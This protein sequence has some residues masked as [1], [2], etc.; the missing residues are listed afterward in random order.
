[1]PSL[2]VRTLIGAVGRRAKKLLPHSIVRWIQQIRGQPYQIPKGSVRFG[3]LRR[4]SPISDD[5][6]SDRGT[7]VDRYY[8]ETF[9]AQSAKDVRGRVLEADSNL[10]TRR[11]GGGRV[12]RSDVLSV[13]ANSHATIVGDLVEVGTL[14]QDAFDCI[15]LTQVLQLIF[16]VRAAVT[17]SYHA[18]KP[19]GV[20]LVTVPGVTKM[21]VERWP[22]Y[23]SFTKKALQR[24]LADQFGDDAVSV[25]AQGNIF[26]ATAFL[27]GIALEELDLSDLNAV[28][29]GY[30]V[31]VAARAIKRKDA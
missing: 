16:D 13:E 9:L 3:D 14:P 11:F 25:E 20:L 18:L 26:A 31:I 8:I 6:G 17:T 4:L 27:Y 29:P 23:W 15:I 10:Y 19:G 12:D 24:L 1:M 22:W 7:P 28:D 30:P 2:T 21:G 5:F